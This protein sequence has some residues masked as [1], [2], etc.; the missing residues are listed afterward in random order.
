MTGVG[1][2]FIIIIIINIKIKS[3]SNIL[4]KFSQE[5]LW[6]NFLVNTNIKKQY[7][8]KTSIN[9]ENNLT[10]HGKYL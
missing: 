4:I 6:I 5:T 3:L 2:F 7:I 8:Y 1:S 9:A 10:A